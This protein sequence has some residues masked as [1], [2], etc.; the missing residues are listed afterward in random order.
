[1]SILLFE[2]A[3]YRPSIA[4]LHTIR[5]GTSAYNHPS[6]PDFYKGSILGDSESLAKL[7]RSVWSEEG[8][9]GAGKLAFAEID[10]A[11]ADYWLD[12]LVAEA[13]GFGFPARLLLLPDATSPYSSAVV[14]ASGVTEGAAHP[15]DRVKF[16]WRDPLAF[17]LD[18]A[19]QG[20]KYGG[21]NTR[22]GAGVDGEADLKGKF[23]PEW[24]GVRRNVSA[25]MV[26]MPNQVF[27]LSR[28]PMHGVTAGYHQGAMLTPG[29]A[30]ASLAALNAGSPASGVFDV[31]LGSGG[32]G[33]YTK[34]GGNI[35][36]G[37]VTWDG[38]EGATAADRTSAQV[39][40]RMLASWGIANVSTADL[41]ACDGRNSGEVGLWLGLDS[42]PRRAAL[43]RM[44]ASGGFVTWL[45][46]AADLW[47]LA[48][49]EAPLLA[50][51]VAT[52]KVLKLGQAATASDGDIIA[53]DWL[54][55]GDGTANP[56]YSCGLTYDHNET[57]QAKDALAGIAWD[58]SGGSRGLVWLSAEWRRV[59]SEDAPLL[60]TFPL[61]RQTDE[62]TLFIDPAVTQ[63]EA[64]RRRT[65]RAVGGPHRARMTVKFGPATASVVDLM[66][67][68]TVQLPRWGMQS[69]RPALVTQI[70]A[71]WHQ[72]IADLYLYL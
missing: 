49:V 62:D 3:V 57:V 65:M 10:V 31:Y 54:N 71:F 11:N 50:D 27:Q 6:A 30:R 25:P 38:H 68:V 9:F 67:T 21:T 26:N 2:A 20:A 42:A 69:G 43:N 8:E 64:A 46:P 47:R 19:A 48:R 22:P 53:W 35:T 41:T 58:A 56:A 14:L 40:K 66:K 5:A 36:G 24:W 16:R 63:T 29:S 7:S 60:S 61:A 51:A 33:C 72:Q 18:K 28:R 44:L 13:C 55:P 59:V 39:W 1:M 34:V 23:V 15:W 45:D 52:F 37:D 17:L 32:D 4:G 70:D 12:W